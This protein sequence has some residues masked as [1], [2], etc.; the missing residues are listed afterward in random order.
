MKPVIAI[1]GGAGTIERS[2]LKPELERQFR[3]TL[4]AALKAGHARLS[5]GADAAEG[6]VAAIQVMEESP[7]FNAGVGSVFTH[8]ES[9]EMDA[10]IMQGQDR[11]A[12]A[13][14]GVGHVA[15]PIALAHAVMR[16]SEHVLLIGVGA[17]EFAVD[18]GFERVPNSYF[19]TDWRRQQLL[20]V[21]DSQ[22][23]LLDH[24]S[25][26]FGTV[27][28]VALDL[29]GNLAAG[30]S[31][32]GMT[33]K[34]YGRVGD[35]PLIGA[36]TYADNETCAVSATG[37]GEYFIRCVAAFNIAA[38]MAF[39]GASLEQAANALVM[40]EL[41]DWGGEGGVIALDTQGRI[42]MPFNSEGM[43]RGFID[44]GGNLE[45]AIFRDE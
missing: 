36:G 39:G 35:S 18:Q 41:K 5:Q 31:T 21:R 29:K 26:K 15:S 4:G 6:V 20:K 14:A 24:D 38:R 16:Q 32:G 45:V 1:H 17:E 22:T 10:S 7:L 3:A 37:H 13:V 28:A 9:I 42:V 43:Y 11:S 2:R 19:E 12:G 23:V 44:A 33:N 25:D 34:R 30:T 40:Q 8:A 27:G